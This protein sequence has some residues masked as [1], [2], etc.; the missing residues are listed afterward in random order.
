MSD[1][2]QGVALIGCVDSRGGFLQTKL[3]PLG[4]ATDSGFLLN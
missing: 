2:V 4:E 1:Q 3:G